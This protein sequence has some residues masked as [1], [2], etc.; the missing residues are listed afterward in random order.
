MRLLHLLKQEV[1]MSMDTTAAAAAVVPATQGDDMVK[2]RT[3]GAVMHA[4]MLARRAAQQEGFV[5][6]T[7]GDGRVAIK[8]CQY[9]KDVAMPEARCAVT[10]Q[11]AAPTAEWKLKM[12][13]LADD[14]AAYAC[15]EYAAEK[16]AAI[17][18]HLES[19]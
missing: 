12:L 4:D 14:Y 10:C 11:Y 18:A 7:D 2:R 9:A 16:R 13:H 17:V 15:T 6:C 1:L 5:S 19:L 3:L 8:P